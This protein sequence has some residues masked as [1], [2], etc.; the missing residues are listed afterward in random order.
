M[1]K[2]D[3]VSAVERPGIMQVP[4]TYL[5]QSGLQPRLE[6]RPFLIYRLPVDILKSGEALLRA[7]R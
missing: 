1:R 2:P 3:T 7:Q 5:Y 4:N 6:L